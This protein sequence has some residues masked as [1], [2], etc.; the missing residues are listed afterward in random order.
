MKQLLF[1]LFVACAVPLCSFASAGEWKILEPREASPAY[2]HAAR[3]FRK[4]YRAVTGRELEIVREAEAGVPL[5]VIGSDCVNRYTRD[6]VERGLIEPLDLG[7]GSDAYRIVSARDGERDLLFLAG[8]NGRATLYAVYESGKPTDAVTA[9][10]FDKESGKLKEINQE[11]VNGTA[12]CYVATNGKYVLTA[13]YGSGSIT[14]LPTGSNGKLLP[15]VQTEQFTLTGEAPDKARQNGPHLHCVKLSPDSTFFVA[16]DLGNDL[17]YVYTFTDNPKK[18]IQQVESVQLP[19]GS[20]PRHITFSED[21][22]Y[23]YLLTELSGKIFVFEVN[24]THLKEVQTIECDKV[25][26]RGSA[27][28]HLSP[29]G[30]Y[31]YASNRLR[32][33]GIAIYKV[34]RENG[35]VSPIAYR[36]T[37]AHPRNFAI[38]PNGKY[39]L[40]ACRDTN[41]IQVFCIN[42]NGTLSIKDTIEIPAPVCV[43]FDE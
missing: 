10:S 15:T 37:A 30:N 17:L 23:A 26:A 9:F 20:G 41:V 39:L 13:N 25:G 2:G 8:G 33:E 24:G 35:T 16:A 27:D 43:L 12:P 18:P 14:V 19:A 7:A 1:S 5:V 6:A 11:T 21:G 40:C 42:S 38:T 34:N 29:D 31:L 36:N 32:N 28:I 22:R 3:E 4:F